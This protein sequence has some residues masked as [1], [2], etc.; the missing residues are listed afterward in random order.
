VRQILLIEDNAGDILL[1]KQVLSQATFATTLR[2][3]MYGEQALKAL[4]DAEFKPDLII[5][6]VN[7]PKAP[8]LEILARRKPTAPVVVFS[9]SSSP[10]EIQG[11]WNVVS[12]SSFR[13]LTTLES[14]RRWS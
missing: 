3:A 1:I 8:G 7:I 11:R 9:S 12:A 4:A 14:L 6:D 13:S 2:V 5:L 10:T